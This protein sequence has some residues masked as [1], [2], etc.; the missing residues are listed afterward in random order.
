MNYL[1]GTTRAGNV[2]ILSPDGTKTVV[3]AHSGEV[4][5]HSQF[6]AEICIT[7]V[8]AESPVAA[9]ELYLPA[10]GAR[11]ILRA[12][13][14]AERAERLASIA[15]QQQ[16]WDA[17]LATMRDAE[18]TANWFRAQSRRRGETIPLADARREFTNLSWRKRVLEDTHAPGHDPDYGHALARRI[19]ALRAAK[20]A[21]G[22]GRP[23]VFIPAMPALRKKLEAIHTARRVAACK[24][25]PHLSG[26]CAASR[27]EYRQLERLPD[28]DLLR[29][30]REPEFLR[31]LDQ[32][33]RAAVRAAKAAAKK[34]AFLRERVLHIADRAAFA[35]G[36]GGRMG[37]GGRTYSKSRKGRS[38]FYCTQHA[39]PGCRVSQKR[40]VVEGTGNRKPVDIGP[41]PPARLLKHLDP[42]IPHPVG[43]IAAPVDG[44]PGVAACFAP[45]EKRRKWIIVGY[46]V[47]GHQV[48]ECVASGTIT[49]ADIA[50]ESNAEVQ[51]I[52]VERYGFDRWLRDS[53]AVAMQEDEYG[54]L[55]AL[56]GGAKL[57]R[58]L[59][60]TANPDGSIN[61]YFL[62]VP[63]HMETAHEA[64]AWSFGCTTATY[65][66]AEQS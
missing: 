46:S 61:E 22:H 55:Y 40:I 10:M 11:I 15:R 39:A 52:L 63:S 56:P 8:E 43:L 9:A 21:L 65:L 64:V 38:G 37:Y 31:H 27:L 35:L 53:G 32:R 26:A 34:S 12:E 59:N 3:V 33:E 62:P 57:A 45:D 58:L 48:P 5:H 42:A 25:W 49:L 47:A 44:Q 28:T 50:A 24:K 66:P 30:E 29:A 19:A 23:A 36:I 41:L 6:P 54:R 4:V 7:P 13:A 16:G 60:S 20:R 18:K 17:Q 2:A 14:D 51:R 1:A